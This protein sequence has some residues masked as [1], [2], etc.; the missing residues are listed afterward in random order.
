MVDL[1]EA[2]LSSA[3]VV[4]EPMTKTTA[5]LLAFLLVLTAC[6]GGSAPD[7]SE[8]AT[9][10]TRDAGTDGDQTAESAVFTPKTLALVDSVPP[11]PEEEP[12]EFLYT[13]GRLWRARPHRLRPFSMS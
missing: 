7:D 9:P 1:P 11:P 4:H 3:V 2:G 5:L 8:T 13:V 12:D 10:E 6:A